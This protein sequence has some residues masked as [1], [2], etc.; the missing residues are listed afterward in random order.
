MKNLTKLIGAIAIG[1]VFGFT[2]A[3][4]FSSLLLTACTGGPQAAEPAVPA[5]A[6]NVEAIYP[7]TAYIAQK[8]EGGARQD[9]ELAAL[10]AISYYFESE[11]NAGQSS[12]SVWTARDGVTSAEFRTETETIVQSQTRMVAVRYAEDPWQNPATGIQN[13]SVMNYLKECLSAY[14][15]MRASPILINPA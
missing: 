6:R 15:G 1:V 2:Y 12:R 10:G 4:L 13:I 11:I 3:F 7:R 9:A 5:W 14:F 8:G